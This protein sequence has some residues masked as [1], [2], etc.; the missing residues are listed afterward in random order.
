VAEKIASLGNTE[1][2]LV[3][4]SGM[5][6]IS[7]VLFTFPGM[8]D[9]V[10]FPK[11]LYGGTSHFMEREF[12]RFGI[13]FSVAKS[14]LAAD[15]KTAIRN[16][17]HICFSGKPAACQHGHRYSRSQRQ[18][19]VPAGDQVKVFGCVSLFQIVV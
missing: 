11:G 3:F 8:G 15:L 1:S 14:Q 2:A 17:Q 18:H 7:T 13:E 6:A 10:V 4:S 16:R 5:A 9:H 12:E 19:T